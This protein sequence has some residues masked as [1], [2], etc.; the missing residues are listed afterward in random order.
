MFLYCPSKGADSQRILEQCSW[1]EANNLQPKLIYLAKRHAS[2]NK[3]QFISRWRSH[4]DLGMSRP[5]WVNIARYEHC[6]VVSPPDLAPYFSQDY[7][8]IG[9]IWHRSPEYRAAHLADSA[10]RSDME[11]DEAETFAEPINNCCALMQEINSFA[12]E[13]HADGETG[14]YRWFRFWRSDHPVFHDHGPATVSARTLQAIKK[15][16]ESAGHAVHYKANLTVAP[17]SEGRAAWGLD[18]ALVEELSLSEASAVMQWRDAVSRSHP[19]GSMSEY[20]VDVLTMPVTL[21]QLG[22]AE[23]M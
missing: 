16:A 13:A 12:S 6:D 5:R 20:V 21:Y 8:G 23:P 10:S 15:Q 4:G 11:R 3:Q 22:Q 17:E 18:V 1:R 7:D 19:E 9:L 2:M 14:F